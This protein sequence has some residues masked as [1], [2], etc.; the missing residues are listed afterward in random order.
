MSG[1]KRKRKELS[2]IPEGDLASLSTFLVANRD[3]FQYL[4]PFIPTR[5][6]AR[7]CA[8]N[9]EIHELCTRT[10]LVRRRIKNELL[11]HMRRVGLPP[12]NYIETYDAPAHAPYM[13][14]TATSGLELKVYPIAHRHSHNIDLRV[15]IYINEVADIRNMDFNIIREIAKL[16]PDPD[17]RIRDHTDGELPW[18]D[19]HWYSHGSMVVVCTVASFRRVAKYV[20]DLI[21][22]LGFDYR[23]HDP[24][25]L[26]H[27]SAEGASDESGWDGS[28]LDE[29][30]D[31]DCEMCGQPATRACSGCYLEHYCSE[32]C[33]QARRPKHMGDCYISEED[34]VT[35]DGPIDWI[36]KKWQNWRER[37]KARRMKKKE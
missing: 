10:K 2:E 11:A 36:K 17:V 15:V 12:E 3:I 5:D 35:V 18:V 1:L 30:M 37:R 14:L 26:D 32:A 34:R 31:I 33:Q 25:W 29:A 21:L 9:K 27:S 19:T 13:T 4:H 7:L 24:Y 23:L 28:S 16:A 8:T 22:G 6:L 20:T